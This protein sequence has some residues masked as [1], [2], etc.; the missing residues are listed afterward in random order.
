MT[1][2]RYTY[3]QNGSAGIAAFCILIFIA[4]FTI[5]VTGHMFAVAKYKNAIKNKYKSIQEANTKLQ[6]IV[7]D[8]QS[9]GKE[10]VDWAGC[11]TL[12]R[13][14]T[15]Y[16]DYGLTVTDVSSGINVNFFPDSEFK[17]SDVEKLLFP[18]ANSSSFLSQHGA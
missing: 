10:D 18:S 15:N 11:S 1:N 13:L 8:F 6:S 12:Q 14:L 7:S 17:R 4:F 9:M 2:K 16:S 3:S 5:A